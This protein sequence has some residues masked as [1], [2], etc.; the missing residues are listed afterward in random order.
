MGCGVLAAYVG[1]LRE[2]LL[3]KAERDAKD[4]LLD[5]LLEANP[6]PVPPSL[7]ERQ[8]AAMLQEVQTMLRFQGMNPDQ[9]AAHTDQM[10]QDLGPR[11]ERE[12]AVSLLLNAVADKEGFSV[13]DEEVQA[14]LET[15][16]EKSGQNLAQL[17]ALYSEPSRIDELKHNLRRDKTVDHLMNLS[18]MKGAKDTSKPADAADAEED[19][20]ATSEAES[21]DEQ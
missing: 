14:H 11:A 10:I 17:K 8:K 2:G 13:D 18:N 19:A 12:V 7:V 21:G 4:K 6:F 15:V 20:M 5:Q 16:A 9:I 1:R 3:T